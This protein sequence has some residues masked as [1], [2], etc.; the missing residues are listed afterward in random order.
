VP[1]KMNAGLLVHNL[2]QGALFGDHLCVIQLKNDQSQSEPAHACGAICGI[3]PPTRNV[4]KRNTWNKVS[5]RVQDLTITVSLNSETVVDAKIQDYPTLQRLATSG[6]FGFINFKG[7]AK[8]CRFR[9]IRVL[10]LTKTVAALPTTPESPVT[11]QADSPP[12]DDSVPTTTIPNPDR[13]DVATSDWVDLLEWSEG[14]DWKSRGYDW[15]ENCEG[16]PGK[17]GITLK[18]TKGLQNIFPLPAIID[19]DYDMEVEFTRHEG[20]H[21]VETLFP[22][23]TKNLQ[24]LLGGYSGK[25]EGVFGED[26]NNLL[27]ESSLGSRTPLTITNHEKHRVAI[28]VR[29]TE[30]QVRLEIDVD[31]HKNYFT[32]SGQRA[33]LDPSLGGRQLTTIRRP[34]IAGYESRVTFDKLRVKMISGTISKDFITQAD[35]DADLANGFVRL[36][37]EPAIKPVVG[38]ARFCVNQLELSDAPDL[39]WPLI[40]RDFAPCRDFYGAHAPSSLKCP[41]PKGARSFTVVG[42]NDASRSTKYV[43]FVDGK[44]IYASGVTGIVPIRID[45][46]RDAGLLELVVETGGNPA[47]DCSY[48]CYPRFHANSLE[49]V[50]E[51]MLDEKSP[52]LKFKIGSH[53]VGD[54]KLTYNQPFSF[55]RSI[56]VDFRDARPCDEFLYAVPNSSV[57]YS[58][59]AGMTRFTAIAYCVVSHH[60]RFEVWADAQQIFTSPQ[61]GILPIDLKLPPDTKTLEL[62][63]NDLGSN[64]EDHCMWCYPRLHRK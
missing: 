23:G 58:V 62:K 16:M 18:P 50:T 46:P 33:E 17:A 21:S 43:V 14:I 25:V 34:W 47:F 1:K 7:L 5:V 26:G 12:S 13:N 44:E 56:P 39:R 27:A 40:T 52:T 45:L 55:C 48:W 9:N 31:Q 20:R 60:A 15:S 29:Q 51:R 53:T 41:I 19:G 64:A 37:G 28:R 54:D 32:W 8:G 6:Y 3:V 49:K 63:I 30:P 61:A 10:D 36:V 35:R 4:V 22:V 57:T 38:F 11:V 42:Y 2:G 59:A 24:L